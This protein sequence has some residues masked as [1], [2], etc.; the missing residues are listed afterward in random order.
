MGT[1]KRTDVSKFLSYVLR[2]A[3]DSIGIVLDS[4]GWVTIDRLLEASVAAG[5]D[6]NLEVLQEVVATSE[7]KRFTVSED[8]SRIRAA[9]G[10]TTSTVS[11]KHESREP[12]AVLYHGTAT[13]FL[14]SILAKG[15]IPGNRHHVHLSEFRDTALEVG[16]RYGKPVLLTVDSKRMSED[17]R[18]FYQAD[19][20]VWLTEEVD[21]RYISVA[22]G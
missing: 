22:D 17:G 8:G 4:D 3:P 1:S 16:K 9:Q 7:K 5:Q 15:L 21:I 14:D 12:P 13:R 11:V 2:H 20:G 18:A 6:L 10:H 19:N